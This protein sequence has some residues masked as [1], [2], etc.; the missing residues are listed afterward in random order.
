MITKKTLENYDDVDNTANKA[1][2]EL[3]EVM[4]SLNRQMSAIHAVNFEDIHYMNFEGMIIEELEHIHQKGLENQRLV[5][6]GK[7]KLHSLMV[8]IIEAD[9]YLRKKLGVRIPGKMIEAGT[10]TVEPL[11]LVAPEVMRVTKTLTAIKLDE[12][13]KTLFN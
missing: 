2:T 13:P 11:V 12:K 6:K 4:E 7:S 1:E 5:E 3:V 10:Q 9:E 8:R